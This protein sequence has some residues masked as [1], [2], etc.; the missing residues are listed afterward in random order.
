MNPVELR[1]L[2]APNLSHIAKSL[3]IFYL[4]P[5]AVQNQCIIDITSIINY[6]FCS[7]KY[8]PTQPNFAVAEKCLDELEE[9]GLVKHTAAQWHGAE[10]TLPL[11]ARDSET[12]PKT[13]FEMT[14]TWEPSSGFHSTA[15]MCGLE[16]SSFTPTELNAFRSYWAG[17]SEKRNQTSWERAFALRLL[18]GR[19]AKIE[20]KPAMSDTAL[21]KV[22]LVEIPK[23]QE[24]APKQEEQQQILQSL[25]DLFK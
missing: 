3:Y 23:P 10:F 16:D 12:L 6:L 21:G 13:P 5:L 9:A 4:R 17:R 20:R 24:S 14:V 18:K 1:Y 8:F 15:L 7:S 25:Q 11:Y 19:E 22:N 2:S